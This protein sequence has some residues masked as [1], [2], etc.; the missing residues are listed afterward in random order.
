MQ[1][2]FQGVIFKDAL[3]AHKCADG[4]PSRYHYHHRVPDLVQ[5]WQDHCHD[6]TVTIVRNDIA[7]MIMNTSPCYEIRKQYRDL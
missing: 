7:V 1:C 2:N 6:A 3:I 5:P 4:N